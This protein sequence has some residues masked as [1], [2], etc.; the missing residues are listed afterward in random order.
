MR[1]DDRRWVRSLP[2]GAI[3]EVVGVSSFPSGPDTWWRPDGTPLHPA[4]C[5][6][7]RPGLSGDRGVPRLIVVRLARIPDGAD[8]HWSITEAM[9]NTTEPA[10]RGSTPLPGLSETTAL[11]PA[12][13]GTC[14]VRFK[15]AA[16]P[17]NTIR[18]WAKNPGG[19]GEFGASF[20]FA[21]PIATQKGTALAVTHNIQDKAVRLIAIDHDD[22]ELP[23]EIRSDAGVKDF[24]QLVVEFKQPPEEIK[25]FQLQVRP[26]EEVEIP[27]IALRRK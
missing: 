8:H 18:T 26:Y 11:L 20:I 5:D 10:M 1:V 27:C 17:W 12:D 4:P 14:T 21:N 22:K 9:G 19:I 6:S 15:V 25:E 7:N 23:A 13:A 24:Q 3:I 2:S 16:G